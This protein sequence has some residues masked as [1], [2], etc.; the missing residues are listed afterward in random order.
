MHHGQ[1]SQGGKI[2]QAWGDLWKGGERWKAGRGRRGN[3]TVEDLDRALRH[4]GATALGADGWRPREIWVLPWVL[5]QGL[6]DLY[7]EAEEKENGQ[8]TWRR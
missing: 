3:Y 6:V 7:N 2:R 4:M 5:T 8:D 1:G